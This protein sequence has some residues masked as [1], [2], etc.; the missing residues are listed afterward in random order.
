MAHPAMD[1]ALA[2]WVFVIF[3]QTGGSYVYTGPYA[4]QTFTAGDKI[5]LIPNTYYPQASDRPL[6]VQIK[7]YSSPDTL[8]DALAAGELDLAFHLPVDRLAAL[9]NVNGVTIKSFNQG[10][11]QYMM[12]HNMRSGK[13]L[14]D[15][16]V[17]QAVDR[18]I[19]R[20]ALAQALAGGDPTRSLFPE[21]SPYFQ[22][23]TLATNAAKSA[24]EALLD[25]AGW[26]L[27]NGKRVKAGSE[28]TLSLISYPFRPGLG[29]MAPHIKASLESVGITVNAQDVDLW[30]SPHDAI[31]S[32]KTYD[33]LMWAQ[34]TL[35]N[36]DPQWFLNAFF[37]GNPM[38]SRN[39]AGVNSSAIDTKLDD[40]AVAEHANNARI[41]AAAAAHS[42]ILAEVAVSN[43]VTPDWHIGM[44]ER[45]Q[46]YD[47]YGAD[48]YV[49]NADFHESST[50]TITTTTITTT[51]ATFTEKW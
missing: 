4:V 48:Y 32:G 47:P 27:Q 3:K 19:D 26:V 17:R 11:Y 42:E 25:D 36:G 38:D 1:A 35:P 49:I 20:Q 5:D 33:L 10:G 46:D 29:I 24:A 16:K 50:T 8:A 13:A 7:K 34:H 12:F 43:L 2:N 14:S 6:F 22:A 39:Y 40:L 28:L 44:S 31:L 23:D 18:V 30:S 21:T 41:N 9:R 15:L 51:T 45:L 37:R